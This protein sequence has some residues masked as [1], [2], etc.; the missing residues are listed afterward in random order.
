MLWQLCHSIFQKNVEVRAHIRAQLIASGFQRILSK[1]ER[2][3]YEVIDKQI[4]RFWTNKAID[5]E[6]LLEWENIL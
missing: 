5:D 3:H 4:E 2:L 1:M 6:G